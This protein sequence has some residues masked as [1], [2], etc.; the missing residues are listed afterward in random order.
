MDLQAAG[1]LGPTP[2]KPILQV[3]CE[4]KGWEEKTTTKQKEP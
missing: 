1:N 2:N 3:W 4:P